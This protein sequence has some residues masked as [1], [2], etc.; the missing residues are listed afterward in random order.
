MAVVGAALVLIGLDAP[1]EVDVDGLLGMG[2][3]PDVAGGQPVVRHLH[4]IAVHQLLAEQAELIADGAAHGGQ[5]Q[6]GQGIQEA[7]GQAAQAAV[8][9]AGLRLFLKDDGAVDAQLVQGLHVILFVDQVHHVVVQG[10]AHQELSGQVV[11]LLGL[12]LL[13]S[14]AGIA[15]ALHDFVAH[16]QRQRLVKLLGRGVVDVAG[17]LG[18]Q[19][20]LDAVL[21]LLYGHPFKFHDNTSGKIWVARALF[22][23]NRLRPSPRAAILQI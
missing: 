7:G 16:H 15:A 13:A 3:L 8:A 17:E 1:A 20:V 22:R 11:D 2:D 4:L 10:A 18:V 12:L 5:L 6:R 21:D 19:F 23:R 14:V 9:Q